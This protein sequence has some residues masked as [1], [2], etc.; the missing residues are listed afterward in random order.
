M[1]RLDIR[2][3]KKKNKKYDAIFTF[4]DGLQKVI[5]FG[6]SGYSDYTQH[7]DDE[8]RQRYIIRHQKNENWNNPFTA[9]ALSYWILWGPYTDIKKNIRLFKNHF[10]FN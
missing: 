9:G 8:R 2:E 10:G 5:S 6:A 4:N 7:H 3:S 1:I